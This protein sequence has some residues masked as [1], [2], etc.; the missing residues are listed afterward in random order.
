MSD[1]PHWIDEMFEE[2]GERDLLAELG[3]TLIDGTPCRRRW[4]IRYKLAPKKSDAMKRR[5]DSP[6]DLR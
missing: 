1:K 3:H 4:W 5:G 2:T 6:G